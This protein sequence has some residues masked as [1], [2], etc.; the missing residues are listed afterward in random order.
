[1][2]I[3]EQVYGRR[4]RTDPT[5]EAGPATTQAAQGVRQTVDDR[6]R[7]ADPALPLV[8]LLGVALAF[9][10]VGVNVNVSAGR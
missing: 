8:V 7:K 2:Q 9:G 1:M 5:G 10:W 6:G 4:Y 3:G